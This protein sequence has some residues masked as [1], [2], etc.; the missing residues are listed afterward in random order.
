MTSHLG[1]VVRD[2]VGCLWVCLRGS[3]RKTAADYNGL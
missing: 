2:R 3:V 1:D